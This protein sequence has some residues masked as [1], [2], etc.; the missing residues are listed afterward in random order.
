LRL[1]VEF[2]KGSARL[3]PCGAANGIDPERAHRGKVDQEPAFTDS[4]PCD[5]VATAAHREQEAVLTR[6]PNGT[7][8]VC[9]ASATDNRARV[10]VDHRIPDRARLIVTRLLRQ[11]K[12][13][14]QRLA[15]RSYR[16]VSKYNR[17]APQRG[18]PD[19]GHGVSSKVFW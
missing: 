4:I 13:A 10:A 19:L 2:A 1:S 5:V 17:P 7:N 12:V 15:K 16:V 14:P 9:G 8:D 18:Q 3:Y 11:A 6:E